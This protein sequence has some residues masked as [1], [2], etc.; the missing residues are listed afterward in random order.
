MLWQDNLFMDVLPK[1]VSTRTICNA[2]DTKEK[3]RSS[4]V[5]YVFRSFL[6]TTMASKY[7]A[8]T[9]LSMMLTQAYT[10]NGSA[11][12]IAFMYIIIIDLLPL[13]ASAR[14]L[15]SDGETCAQV[16]HRMSATGD[17]K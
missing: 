1:S 7:A 2:K 8:A 5:L 3:R 15:L 6:S 12:A 10:P 17:L 14:P 13:T 4:T 11:D 16:F 9:A